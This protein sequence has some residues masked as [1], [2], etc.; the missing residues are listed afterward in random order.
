M[1]SRDDG[2]RLD[3]DALGEVRV[4]AGALYGAHTVRALDNFPLA[5]RPIHPE[6][7]RAFGSVKLACARA[8]RDLGAWSGDPPKSDAIE[9]ACREMAEGR[10]TEHVVVDAPEK[11]DRRPQLDCQLLEALAVPTGSAD[12]DFEL[13]ELRLK[14]RR[15]LDQRIHS[16]SWH[17]ARK[18]TDEERSGTQSE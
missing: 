3:H 18:G 5:R 2:F 14:T 8:N 17:Q 16:L 1:D 10:L 9:A 4:P 12:G 13:G 15:R 7:V 6:L 11:R